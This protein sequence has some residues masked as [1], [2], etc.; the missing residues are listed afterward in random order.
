MSLPVPVDADETKI[1]AKFETCQMQ[2]GCWDRKS[3]SEFL[4]LGIERLAGCNQ[5][6]TQFSPIVKPMTFQASSEEFK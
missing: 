6:R 4:G 2:A 5:Q 1:E 3:E